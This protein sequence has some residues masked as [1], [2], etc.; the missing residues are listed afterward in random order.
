MKILLIGDIV[1]SGGRQAVNK[2]A[3][4]L[5]EEY[6]CDFI[7][8]N[9]ENMAGGK[10]M[11]NKTLKHLEPAQIDVITS[12]DHIWDQR[13]FLD[14]ITGHDHILRPANLQQGLP[15]KGHGIY[16]LSS[17]IK[18]GV[19]NLLGRVFMAQASDCPF[20]C[21][22]RILEEIHKETDL[23]FVDFHAEAT[24]EKIAMGRFLDGRVTCVFGT[25]TH[26]QTADNQVFTNGT[27]YLTDLGMVGSKNSILGRKIAPV[28][29]KFA[30]GIPKYFEVEKKNIELRGAVVEVEPSTGK[31]ISIELI[32]RNYDDEE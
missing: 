28:V 16:T 11:N 5:R 25:H 8:A 29:Q 2:L 6:Q 19:I 1:G 7:I 10:G 30:T 13:Q 4:L 27:A 26:V 12:G 3:P 9:G 22:E 23:I 32:Q 21:V 18:I 14:E 15:G 31:A 17:G 24:S 20:Q